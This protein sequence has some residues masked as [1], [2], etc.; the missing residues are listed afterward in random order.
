MIHMLVWF[1]VFVDTVQLEKGYFLLS[2][3]V[4]FNY[5]IM[6]ECNNPEKEEN[7]E[8]SKE[9]SVVESTE[10]VEESKEENPY[11][12]LN[13][14]FSSENFKIEVKNLPKFYGFN[15]RL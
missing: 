12:Y 10:S 13:R 11:A 9:K 4:I 3:S 5:F 6:S 15:V 2:N 1:Y 8:E 7:I 14:D